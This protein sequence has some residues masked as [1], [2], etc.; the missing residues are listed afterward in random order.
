MSREEYDS[1]FA[2]EKRVGIHGRIRYRGASKQIY[3]SRFFWWFF[4]DEGQVVA[5]ALTKELND[6]T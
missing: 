5:R 6:H 2:D 1:A 3:E 4:F